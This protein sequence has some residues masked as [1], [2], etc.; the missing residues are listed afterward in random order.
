MPAHIP[1]APRQS[2]DWDQRFLGLARQIAGFSKDPSTKV[3][4]VAVRERRILATG[5]NGL[6]QH[7][8]DTNERLERR[9]VRL[10]MTVHAEANLIAHAARHG[11]CL[12]SSTIYIWPLMA[13]A[14]CAAQLIQVDC[15]RIVVP[16]YIEPVRW[17]DSFSFA[18][19]MFT[20]AGVTVERLPL[21]GPRRALLDDERDGDALDALI[22]GALDLPGAPP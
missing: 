15:S 7:V 6:P 5:Y 9:D 11:V 21:H 18:R 13:C 10:A 2:A 16:D 20:E 3:G 17:S 12:A 14:Q 22:D 4:A 19:Q 1:R 8:A